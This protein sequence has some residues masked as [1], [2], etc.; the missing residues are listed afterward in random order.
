MRTQ[1]SIPA[2]ILALVTLAACGSQTVSGSGGE[3]GGHKA[4]ADLAI[5]D[6]HWTIESLTSEGRKTK[7]PAG[8][9]LHFPAEGTVQGETGCNGFRADAELE[10]DI[11][12]LSPAER[13][14]IGCPGPAAD[15]EDTL[16]SVIE[17]RLK[18]DLS[19]DE[20]KLTLTN[21]RG[22]D[23][24]TLTIEPPAPLLGTKWT[25][26]SLITA[27]TAASVPAGAEGAAHL[28]FRKDGTVAGNLGCNTFSGTAKVSGSKIVLGRITSTKMLC[29]G[30]KGQVEAHLRKVLDRQVTFSV[31][32]RQ[33]TLT[34]PADKRLAAVAGG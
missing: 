21:R 22:G 5:T 10:G 14:E 25:V 3:A 34:G 8:A 15:F 6:V 1:L 2:A 32:H 7:A 26:N 11:L 17:G 30:A 16:L 20:K 9:S 23:T 28:V 4:L 31:Q 13:T 27:D 33:M 29:D 18:A 12:V 19:D 24:V